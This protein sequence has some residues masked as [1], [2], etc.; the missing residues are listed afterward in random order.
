MPR[1]FYPIV[2]PH[3]PSAIPSVKHDYRYI[4][5]VGIQYWG[6]KQA[7]LNADRQYLRDLKDAGV[8]AS[9]AKLMYLAIRLFGVFWW[10]KHIS[11]R[12]LELTK[13]QHGTTFC[14]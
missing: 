10:N 7:R 6:H 12:L 8:N 1:L 11:R 2:P 3:G 4:N 13:D 9:V 14:G 5:L